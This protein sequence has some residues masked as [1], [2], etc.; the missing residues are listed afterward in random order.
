[1]SDARPIPYGAWPSPITADRAAKASV[2]LSETRAIG[3]STTWLELRP[4]EQG[5]SV[6]VRSEPGAEPVDVTPAG[7]SVRTRVHEYGGGS[8]T[9]SGTNVYFS[10]LDDQRL[11]R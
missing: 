6:V 11:H 1:M 2:R 9:A 8:Y 4:E 3:E 7:L 5:R 10:N